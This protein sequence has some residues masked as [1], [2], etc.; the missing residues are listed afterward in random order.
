M[1]M[2]IGAIGRSYLASA[3]A[4]WMKIGALGAKSGIKIGNMNSLRD[5]GLSDAKA[6]VELSDLKALEETLKEIGPNAL[7]RFKYNAR[8]LGEPAKRSI[9]GTF[10]GVGIHGP[11]GG[12]KRPGRN[13]DRMSTNYGHAR[14]NWLYSRGLA[15]GSRGIDVNYKNR[16][17]GK[18]LR[19]LQA[20]RDGTISIVRVIVKSPAYIL[21]DMAGK[22]GKAK[23]AVG[24][25]TRPYDQ[26]LFGRGKVTRTH[27]ITAAR[28]QAIDNWIEALDRKAHNRRQNDASR[29]AWP[30]MQK[31]MGQHKELTSKLFNETISE[32]NKRLT[33]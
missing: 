21:A 6:V 29:Y 4:S 32:I 10:A 12:P 27:V 22:S 19:D 31:H 24:S 9:R 16:R 14:L 33:S 26:N 20:A 25:T 13:Y 8:K 7:R 5:L 28:R 17:E 15:Q 3:A 23:M 18:A 2:F 11:L 30:T 1:S